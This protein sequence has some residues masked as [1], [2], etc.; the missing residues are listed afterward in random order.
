[1]FFTT[2]K[3]NNFTVSSQTSTVSQEFGRFR[4]VCERKKGWV[5]K[6]DKKFI[7]IFKG[8]LYPDISFSIDDM[9]Q[10]FQKGNIGKNFKRFKGRFCGCFVDRRSEKV[11][12]FTDQ[13][14]LNDLFY[15][16]YNDQII[17]S[18]SFNDFFRMHKFL[19]DEIDKTAFAEF[20]IFQHP[21][22]DRTFVRSI[23]LLPYATIKVFNLIQGTITDI[24][25]WKYEFTTKEGFDSLIA[26]K[27]LDMLLQQAMRRI[28]TLN[29]G[30]DFLLGLS[31][32]LDSRLVAKYALREHLPL[33]CFVFGH[34]NSDA[35][36]VSQKVADILDVPLKK[37]EIRDDFWNL[38]KKHMRY[39]P[40]INVMVAAYGTVRLNLPS[41]K[42]LL[43][44]FYGGELFGNHMST[45]FDSLIN[46]RFLSKDFLS[47]KILAEVQKDIA[48]Y[49]QGV[50]LIETQRFDFENRQLRFVKNNPPFHF[51][52][53]FSQSFSPF[54]DIDVVEHVLS[55]PPEKHF[56][57][58]FYHEFFQYYLP[59][60]VKVR[61]ERIPYNVLEKNK[62]IKN[63][64]T[65]L[66]KGKIFFKKK[67]GITV[68]V[69]TDIGFTGALNWARLF[70]CVPNNEIL[71]RLKVEGID[72]RRIQKHHD[73]VVKF[74][75][76]TLKKFVEMYVI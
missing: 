43:S 53:V 51:Y 16:H 67:F 3:K 70:Q 19:K 27:K 69:F 38:Q 57:C 56:Q 13:L 72:D 23:K 44:G 61:P 20:L 10:Y 62:S 39:D 34:K 12:I 5:V 22:L 68:P 32:G 63:L 58:N 37:L 17:I 15:F 6:R 1:M 76:I 9:F 11:L 28:H 18:D 21:L 36:N 49:K 14:G 59:E 25:Y 52:G 64:K 33:E 26:L 75:Y 4:F 41:D 31:G 24:K 42:I 47:Q 45:N 50:S 71:G 35:F 55:I 40:M 73:P 74:C 65:I 54:V 46:K 2:L 8:Y 48:E 7:L 60:L 30:K 66:L 29:Y